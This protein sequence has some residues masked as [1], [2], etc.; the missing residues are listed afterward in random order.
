M[1]PALHNDVLETDSHP[2]LLA[3]IGLRLVLADSQ[4]VLGC[5]VL[6]EVA[7]SVIER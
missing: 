1:L 7:A 5:L 3:V 4:L 6:R 2:G